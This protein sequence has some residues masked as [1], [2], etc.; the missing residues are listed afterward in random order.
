MARSVGLVYISD[1]RSGFTRSPKTR[2]GF[3]FFDVHGKPLRNKAHLKR[4]H[5]LVLPPAWTDI[6][7]CPLANGHLQATGRDA[8]GRKQYRYHANWSRARSE[9]KFSKMLLFAEKLPKIRAQ[10]RRDLREE[11]LGRKRVTASVVEIMEQT[12][13]RIGN[14]EYAKE[15]SSYG[16]TTMLNRHVT[17][18]GA[19]IH[20]KFKGKSGKWHDVKLED[21][22]LA[23]IVHRCQDLPGQDLFEYLADDGKVVNITSADVNEYLMEITKEHITAKDFRTWGGTV[24]A[25]VKLSELGPCK[26]KREL[27][28]SLLRA[29]EETSTHLRNTISVCRKYYIHPVVFASYENGL[30]FKIHS[31][32]RRLR[33]KGPRGLHPEEIFTLKILQSAKIGF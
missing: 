2:S 4:I 17:V 25:A 18:K 29:T 15:N 19:K 16:L 24:K 7:I 30:L 14:A 28:Q 26:T 12:L 5:S 11:G 9:N 21:Q 22:K 31:Q 33:G 23:R 13:I 20:F 3:Q 27:K 1:Q 32:C 10:I 8:R 6:W